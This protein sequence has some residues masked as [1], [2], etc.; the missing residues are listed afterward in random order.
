VDRISRCGA[1][2]L[3]VLSGG[4]AMAQVDVPG[5]EVDEAAGIRTRLAEFGLTFDVDIVADYSMVLSGGAN[6]R[7]IADRFLAQAGL[8]LDTD[9]AFGW[10][11]GQFFITYQGFHGDDG[12]LD[13][14]DVQVYSNIDAMPFDALYS[15]YYEQR[16]VD[17]QFSIKLGKMDAN[18]DF[19]Y[20]NNG[21]AFINSS[22]G[23][24]P[25]IL[26][27]PSYPDPSTAVNVFW[28]DRRGPYLGAGVYDGATQDG[29]ATG[30]RGP[31]TF[32]GPPDATFYIAEAGAAYELLGQPG[33]LG[34]GAWH[35]TG[36]FERFNATE[37][38][39]A[40]G[41]YIV[42]DQT[43]YSA[44]G[45]V[46][47]L[48]G[49]AQYGRADGAVSPLTDHASAGVTLSAPATD[50]PDDAVGLMAS[51]VAF[52][53]APGAGFQA[54]YELAIEAFYAVLLGRVLRV[55][56][57]LQYI[58]NPGGQGLANA[59]VSTLRLEASF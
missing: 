51:Y 43:L 16:L 47:Q 21:A 59:T 1:V 34:V 28:Q 5:R 56:P 39:H 40:N 7:G 3:G 44:A 57:D 37:T 46:R 22:P 35:H 20:V 19:A 13:S 58:A 41:S 23:F 14:G 33:R 42:L 9:K 32:F 6:P 10:P 24:S 55:K 49:F 48:D 36:T 53:D 12:S 54:D 31:S 38:D 15:L 2:I 52:S 4:T 18:A 25:T 11:G 30:T 17:E 27:F 50:R 8:T 45:S 26:S 29:V